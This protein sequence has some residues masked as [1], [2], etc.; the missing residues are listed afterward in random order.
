MFSS[1]VFTS[2]KYCQSNISPVIL[3]L[4][5]RPNAY[6]KC[7]YFRRGYSRLYTYASNHTLS[8]RASR[9]T[10][11]L[12]TSKP[13]KQ[14][15]SMRPD[16]TKLIL[17]HEFKVARDT[18]IFRYDEP[19]LFRIMNIFA[20]SQFFFWA[21][22]SHFAFTSMRD[23]PIS[24][25][26]KNNENLSWWKKINF[27]KYKNALTVGSFMIGW[28][29]MAFVWLY[30]LR[31]VRYLVLKKGGESLMFVTYT[32]FNRKQYMTVPLQHVSAKQSRTTSKVYLPLKVKGKYLYYVLD[33]RGQFPNTRLFDYSAGLQRNWAFRK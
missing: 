29:T 4:K 30:T 12:H 9:S 3:A 21:Y 20:M 23:I 27:G 16:E 10:R 15:P 17:D 26:E 18:V 8:I 7:M 14:N 25:E 22:L 19:R 5:L 33:M 1:F 32:P 2:V 6:S 24:E 13:Q 31:C 11:L 28:S